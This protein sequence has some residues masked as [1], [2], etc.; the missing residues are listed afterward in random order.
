MR[1]LVVLRVDRKSDLVLNH[2]VFDGIEEM[3]R[4]LLALSDD[5]RGEIGDL[6][7]YGQYNSSDG[8]TYLCREFRY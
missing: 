6:D 5:L 4:T 3:G 8:S 2:W 7:Y 1:R